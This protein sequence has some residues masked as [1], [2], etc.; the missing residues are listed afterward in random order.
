M[1]SSVGNFYKAVADYTAVEDTELTF[2]TGDT[3]E[4]LRTGD[5]GWWFMRNKSTNHEG[6]APASYMEQQSRDS[7]II[8]DGM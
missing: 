4:M 2:E 8:L 6:W 3:L 5:D 7:G 1:R